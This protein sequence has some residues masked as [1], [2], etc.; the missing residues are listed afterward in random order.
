MVKSDVVIPISVRDDPLPEYGDKKQLTRASLLG[1]TEFLGLYESAVREDQEDAVLADLVRTSATET[2]LPL[3]VE[4]VAFNINWDFLVSLRLAAPAVTD[5]A[6]RRI[7]LH[8][9]SLMRSGESTPS[10]SGAP[11]ALSDFI[12]NYTLHFPRSLSLDDI[13]EL[14]KE[15]VARSFRGWFY[16]ALSK[17]RTS[18]GPPSATVDRQ[19]LS[20]FQEL[21]DSRS[22]KRLAARTVVVAIAAGAS[23]SLG[24]AAG[25]V[26]LG[27]GFAFDTLVSRAAARWGSARWIDVFTR[28][29]KG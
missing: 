19:L 11:K 10:T 22:R 24:L 7:C 13:L 29:R 18:L 5:E 27:A 21:L 4:S 3:S 2:G 16:R 20:Q 25:G 1:D 12:E 26:T 8:K 28:I 23:A 9:L 17:T 6:L 15:K 14:R